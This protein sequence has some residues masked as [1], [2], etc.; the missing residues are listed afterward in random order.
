MCLNEYAQNLNLSENEKNM[1]YVIEFILKEFEEPFID[2]RKEYSTK[3]DQEE[4]F[5][6]LTEENPYNLKEES[7]KTVKIFS[8]DDR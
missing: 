7:M 6:A 5:Y 2:N 4:I 3:S 1:N 8:I